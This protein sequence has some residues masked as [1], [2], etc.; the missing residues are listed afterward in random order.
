MATRNGTRFATKCDWC[1]RLFATN[2]RRARFCCDNHRL[3]SYRADKSGD[4]RS[5][6][7]LGQQAIDRLQQILMVSEPAYNVIFRLLSDYG[8]RVATEAIQASFFVLDTMY[9]ELNK[10]NA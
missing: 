6:N 1:G 5:L 10:D 4:G 8:A 9:Q 2:S 7:D 3:A